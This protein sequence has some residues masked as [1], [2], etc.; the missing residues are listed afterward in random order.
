M[1][2]EQFE[3]SQC[4]G[5]E[6]F[7]WNY[8]KCELKNLQG[9]AQEGVEDT[10]MGRYIPGRDGRIR[11]N[12]D[13]ATNDPGSIASCFPDRE[14]QLPALL[15]ASWR[16]DKVQ[17]KATERWLAV[18]VFAFFLFS[19]PRGPYVQ[20]ALVLR[21]TITPVERMRNTPYP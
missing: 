12:A 4:S 21:S 7:V 11:R 19:T 17:R 8:M 16:L 1:P 2:N 6:Q 20:D 14:C 3:M 15:Q 9:V 18:E 10:G 13:V 5:W